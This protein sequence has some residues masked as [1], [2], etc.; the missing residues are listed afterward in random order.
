MTVRREDNIAWL[1]GV[2]R[3]EEAEVLAGHLGAGAGV[4]DLSRC[5]GLHAAVVQV[6]L[7]WRPQL[8]GA[9]DEAF[10]RDHLLPALAGDAHMT[11]SALVGDKEAAPSAPGSERIEG[12][13]I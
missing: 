7:A 9:P 3:V 2:C 4:V 12:V 11:T 10:L 8:R 1:E 13:R 6:L 5:Q